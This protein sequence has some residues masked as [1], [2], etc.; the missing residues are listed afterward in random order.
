MK[1]KNVFIKIVFLVVLIAVFGYIG[2]FTSL[3]GMF[4]NLTEDVTGKAYSGIPSSFKYKFDKYLPSS[5]INNI[6]NISPINSIS[7]SA[8]VVSET[9][10]HVDASYTGNVSDGSMEK[11]WKTISEAASFN[12]LPGD[13]VIVHTGTYRES[14]RIN[15]KG[16]KKGPITF[17][18]D[19][20]VIIKGSEHIVGW[21]STGGAIYSHKNWIYKEPYVV[22]SSQV[23]PGLMLHN[24]LR[25]KAT[26]E[27]IDYFKR[28]YGNENV[29]VVQDWEQVDLNWVQVQKVDLSKYYENLGITFEWT[30]DYAN[31][32]ITPDERYWNYAEN[33]WRPYVIVRNWDKGQEFLRKEF[34]EVLYSL[35]RNQVFVD[36]KPLREVVAKDALSPG[37]F[38]INP[39]TKELSVFLADSS[40]PTTHTIEG[41]T[42]DALVNFGQYSSSIVFKGFKLRHSSSPI[43]GR[44]WAERTPENADQIR[45]TENAVVLSGM[46]HVFENNQISF[47]NGIGLAIGPK[48]PPQQ[49]TGLQLPNYDYAELNYNEEVPK[50]NQGHIIKGNTIERSGFLGVAA[51]ASTGVKFH[52]NTVR[53]N[54]FKMRFLNPSWGAGGMKLGIVINWD[55]KGLRSYYNFNHGIWFDMGCFGN[56]IQNS[57]FYGNGAGIRLEWCNAKTPEQRNLISNNIIYSNRQ[58]IASN[59]VG[60]LTVSNN[61]VAYNDFGVTIIGEVISPEKT[62]TITGNLITDNEMASILYNTYSDNT[63]FDNNL[64]YGVLECRTAQGDD[65]SQLSYWKRQEALEKDIDRLDFSAEEKETLKKQLRYVHGY[66]N[67]NGYVANRFYSYIR[68]LSD[69][70]QS[71]DVW[72]T[73]ATFENYDYEN[74][75]NAAANVQANYKGTYP[76]ASANTGWQTVPLP[77]EYK[78]DQYLRIPL[79]PDQKSIYANPKYS[80]P[81]NMN[82]CLTQDSIARKKG[83]GPAVLRDCKIM[84][85]TAVQQ[86]IQ[87]IQKY[88]R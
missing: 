52:D 41:S 74:A 48:Q 36:E 25:K 20:Q 40:N 42:R 85:S 37:T 53:Y 33:Y 5:Q 43:T 56:K 44:L 54:S 15:H 3:N 26:N 12:L 70:Q 2:I 11:P 55:I 67:W 18:A 76:S 80:D 7:S 66:P 38:Y 86:P 47:V 29:A 28:T 21:E 58:G 73:D 31:L 68:N 49:P 1:N 22:E 81:V 45:V 23:T 34:P 84:A 71:T 79:K 61:L 39:E 69:W 63:L 77:D 60:Y 72:S 17:L 16:T 75:A 82:F 50:W 14:V 32:N 8:E 83:I 27:E 13:S 4:E 59:G 65:C 51:I 9:A 64:Y 78:T 24:K 57:T 62:N 30:R 46:N 88:K 6:S 87:S 19:G 10:Y 35:S